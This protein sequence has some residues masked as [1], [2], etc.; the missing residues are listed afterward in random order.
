MICL[1]QQKIF[2]RQDFHCCC[3]AG[4][5]IFCGDWQFCLVR[6]FVGQNLRQ[7]FFHG[8]VFFQGGA[9]L[10]EV[11]GGEALVVVS[12]E[13][14]KKWKR[15]Q[16]SL[17]SKKFKEQNCKIAKFQ[18][19]SFVEVKYICPGERRLR[20]MDWTSLP[21]GNWMEFG[22]RKFGQSWS[23]FEIRRGAPVTGTLGR[24]WAQLYLC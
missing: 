17:D 9:G 1:P 12:S 24:Y 18:M 23:W 11:Q 2:P 20:K 10:A 15:V 8:S 22:I 19:K 5:R 4:W 14:F 13:N 21:G 7:F 16:N 6:I 3:V